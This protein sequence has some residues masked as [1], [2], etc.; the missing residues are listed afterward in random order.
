[1]R[2]MILLIICI[3]MDFIIVNAIRREEVVSIPGCNETLEWLLAETYQEA[4]VYSI[5]VIDA[6]GRKIAEKKDMTCQYVIDSSMYCDIRNTSNKEW[7]FAVVLFNVTRA[8]SGNYTGQIKYGPRMEINSTV[9]LKVIDKPQIKEARKSILHEPLNI[10]CSV[11]GEL[12]DPVY[13]WKLNGTYLNSTD[14]I[15]ADHFTLIFERVTLLDTFTLFSCI[16]CSSI[17]CCIESD[18]YVPDPN[19]NFDSRM[20]GIYRRFGTNP[21]TGVTVKSEPIILYYVQDIRCKEYWIGTLI[22]S[23]FLLIVGSLLYVKQRRQSLARE[24]DSNTSSDA[25]INR[26]PFCMGMTGKRKKATK[27]LMTVNMKKKANNEDCNTCPQPEDLNN[28]R[29]ENAELNLQ[30]DSYRKLDQTALSLYDYATCTVSEENTNST[31]SSNKYSLYENVSSSAMCQV[32]KADV[33]VTDENYITPIK[34]PDCSIEQCENGVTDV[35]ESDQ[36]YI[37]YITPISDFAC[38][39]QMRHATDRTPIGK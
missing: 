8:S 10:L 23:V 17:N 9:Q 33:H 1:M 28:P 19:G 37:T 30:E 15:W 4:F 3:S 21:R 36:A 39:I 31:E 5:T 25:E 6:N 24:P 34:D 18:A 38:P 7:T 16:V 27:L 13:Y 32:E 12:Q 20:T 2:A 14:R 26:K 22:V 29:Q 11:D 35:I